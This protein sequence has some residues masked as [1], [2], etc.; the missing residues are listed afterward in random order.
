M[1]ETESFF[2]SLFLLGVYH[3][4]GNVNAKGSRIQDPASHIRYLYSST[5][6]DSGNFSLP[7]T[8]EEQKVN[9]YV[10]QWNGPNVRGIKSQAFQILRN[11]VRKCSLVCKLKHL[12]NFGFSQQSLWKKGNQWLGENPVK[13]SSGR[14]KQP[15]DPHGN[16]I[17][18]VSR[19]V[20]RGCRGS[21][22]RDELL[23]RNRYNILK[24]TGLH[25]VVT[26][27]GMTKMHVD[28]F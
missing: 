28:A 15:I 12:F 22:G 8:S 10:I 11:I 14:E 16:L 4:D 3:S 19:P 25:W 20:S 2:L 5:R 6:L 18:V 23:W 21:A 17:G 13:S 7:R 1:R 24:G 9:D 27:Q 26:T